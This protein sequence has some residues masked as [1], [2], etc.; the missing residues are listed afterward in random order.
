[1]QV[2]VVTW[3]IVA[4][5]KVHQYLEERTL[6]KKEASNKSGLSFPLKVVGN[7]EEGSLS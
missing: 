5:L 6:H 7:K 2:L 3:K 1:M 4:M